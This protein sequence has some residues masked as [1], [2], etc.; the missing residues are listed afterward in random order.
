MSDSSSASR[1][2]PTLGRAGGQ[3]WDVKHGAWSFLFSFCRMGEFKSKPFFFKFCYFQNNP[4][5]CPIQALLHINKQHTAQN[6]LSTNL[7]THIATTILQPKYTSWFFQFFNQYFLLEIPTL[8][9]PFQIIY[10]SKERGRF[11][12]PDCLV[13]YFGLEKQY[14]I[15]GN[16]PLWWYCMFFW[17]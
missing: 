2:F 10:F 17:V 6:K 15:P 1:L 16:F 4:L 12:R 13:V 8:W 9:F 7:C 5:F 11:S 3:L 14:K